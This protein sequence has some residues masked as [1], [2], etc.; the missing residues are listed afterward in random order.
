FS[1]SSEYVAKGPDLV[2]FV[3]AR[4]MGGKVLPTN[5]DL[6]TGARI[7]RVGIDTASMSR[8]YPTDLALIGDV[9]ESLKDLTS[10]LESSL[11]KDS[12]KTTARD[13]S[14]EIR[15]IADAARAKTTNAMKAN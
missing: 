7:V 11:A 15:S 14:A 1:M 3:G 6:P 9:K 13:R 12:T 4:D 2:V 5:A 8:N 10:A